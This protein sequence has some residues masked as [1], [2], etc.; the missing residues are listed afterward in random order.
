MHHFVSSQWALAYVINFM[1]SILSLYGVFVCHRLRGSIFIYH[2]FVRGV[3][4]VFA[5]VLTCSNFS[6]SSCVTFFM[7]YKNGEKY[8][9][10]FLLVPFKIILICYWVLSFIKKGE[11]VSFHEA[12]TVFINMFWWKTK[13]QVLQS[14]DILIILWNYYL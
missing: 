9:E 3:L 11:I 8:L 10:N 2:W 4:Y 14:C 1:V 13:R 6:F 12:L 5:I 7:K